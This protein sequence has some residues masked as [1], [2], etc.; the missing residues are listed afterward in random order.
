MSPAIALINLFIEY[1]LS[2]GTRQ[3]LLLR[4]K[5][6]F[7]ESIDVLHGITVTIVHTDHL[8]HCHA[9]ARSQYQRTKPVSEHVASAGGQQV[10]IHDGLLHRLWI[11]GYGHQSFNNC[12]PWIDDLT[13]NLLRSED[14]QR[15]HYAAEG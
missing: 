3:S 7:A 2:Y 6:V 8:R 11:T 15:T 1:G 12:Q 14:Q 10:R 9:R 4:S 13:T 5:V